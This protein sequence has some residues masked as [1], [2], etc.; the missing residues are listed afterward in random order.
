MA[1][2]E[3]RDSPAVLTGAVEPLEGGKLV[4]NPDVEGTE[5]E[6]SQRWSFERL[7]EQTNIPLT[8]TARG[9]PKSPRTWHHEAPV[10][11]TVFH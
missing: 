5:Y 10:G 7:L 6:I 9:L 4:V 8:L 1:K 3:V 2:V 11:F